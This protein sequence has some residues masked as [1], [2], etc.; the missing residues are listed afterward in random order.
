MK[1]DVFV[2]NTIVLIGSTLGLL[3]LLHWI[4]RRQL[5]SAAERN[6]PLP[7]LNSISLAQQDSGQMTITE[8][9][10]TTKSQRLIV[11][12]S[13]SDA[14][15]LYATQVFVGDPFIFPRAKREAHTGFERSGDRSGAEDRRRRTSLSSLSAARARGA[16]E[17]KQ[18]AAL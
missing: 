14:D 6:E 9:K 15:M 11:A 8:L 3:G 16:G 5:G 18:S 1:V 7:Y 12:P 13:D 2:F 10:T 17:S 4:L